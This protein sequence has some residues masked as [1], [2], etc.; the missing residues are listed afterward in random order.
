M[1][2]RSEAMLPRMVRWL[3]WSLVP[4]VIAA[5]P[6]GLV[7]AD[8]R[9]D[10]EI[11]RGFAISVDSTGY[12]LPVNV[13]VVPQPGPAP[14]DALYYVVELRGRVKVVTNDRTV[15]L[16]AERIGDFRPRSELPSPEGEAGATGICLDAETGYV[17][18]TFVY[19]DETAVLRNDIIRYETQPEEFSLSPKS[20]QR[21]TEVFFGDSSAL[22]HQIGPCQVKDRHLYVSVGDGMRPNL[23]RSL[24]STSGKI[25]RMTLDGAPVHSNPFYSDDVVSRPSNYVWA[26]GL[27]NPFG[28]RVEGDRA[29]VADNGTAI[30]RFLHVEAGDDCLWDG[31]DWSIGARADLIFSPAVSPVGL[32]LNRRKKGGFP[33]RY[34][35]SVFLAISG[36]EA[37]RTTGDRGILSF[38]YDFERARLLSRPTYFLRY[39]GNG[40]QLPV[41]LA[42][43]RDGLLF[44]PLMP[45]ATGESPIL[46]ITHDPDAS[47][48][49]ALDDVAKYYDNP[50]A[51]L[52]MK[53]CYDCH[54]GRDADFNV[55]PSLDRGVLTRRLSARLNSKQYE[56]SVQALVSRGGIWHARRSKYDEILRARGRERARRWMVY[57][58][59]EPGFDN[60]DSKM[61]NLGLTMEEAVIIADYLL[62]L[63]TMGGRVRAT[64]NRAL[65]MPRH[66][67]SIVALV[68][69]GSMGI[70]LGAGLVVSLRRWRSRVSGD[71]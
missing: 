1:P 38:R 55:G 15:H 52:R 37:D 12:E 32:E 24:D 39:R 17:F 60:P 31:T 54:S 51:L 49:Y 48:P 8:W 42:F 50:S 46:R 9:E 59:L 27:R 3:C 36:P 58:L 57:Q 35:D 34:L 16:F 4:C 62:P 44:V 13:A 47:H 18:V 70:A 5:L 69:G 19:R 30:D 26:Y 41:G 66:R 11:A 61:P 20:E 6:A 67:H 40:V 10:W 33:A 23:A 64:M 28:L 22:S 21:F 14:S 2:A 45:H 25:L 43:G 63:G 71:A 68:V 56:E 65:G 29:F 53:G 7:R